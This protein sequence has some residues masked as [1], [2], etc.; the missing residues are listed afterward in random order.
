[1][2]QLFGS[3]LLPCVALCTMPTSVQATVPVKSQNSCMS[4]VVTV[5]A[6]NSKCAEGEW[7]EEEKEGRKRRKEGKKKK[8]QVKKDPKEE[9]TKE[10]PDEIESKKTTAHRQGWGGR[11]TFLSRCGCKTP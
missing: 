8:K 4:P 11:K 7:W 3:L 1:M 2:N 10:N 5:S 6:R 9:A